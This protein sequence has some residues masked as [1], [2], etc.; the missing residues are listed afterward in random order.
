[1]PRAKPQTDQAPETPETPVETPVGEMSED[2]AALFR[3]FGQAMLEVAH[4]R[5]QR[6]ATLDELFDQVKALS[7]EDRAALFA[8]PE[9]QSL[10]EHSTQE[11]AKGDAKKADPPGT[12]YDRG[13]PNERKKV[14]T[15]SDL[16]NPRSVEPT[17]MP[18]DPCPEGTYPWVFNHPVHKTTSVVWQGI[19]MTLFRGTRYTGPACFVDTITEGERLEDVAEQHAA[20]MFKARQDPPAEPGIVN[21]H[22]RNVRAQS[23]TIPGL[24]SPYRPGAGVSAEPGAGWV[25]APGTARMEGGEA[26]SEPEAA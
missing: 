14:W 21:Q 4:D 15:L 7:K 23:S 26:E 9:F 16:R 17:W 25:D 2:A 19:P 1:M 13:R 11:R 5:K 20:Y 22:T 18:G 8:R 12:V 3:R 10:V 6:D 24:P